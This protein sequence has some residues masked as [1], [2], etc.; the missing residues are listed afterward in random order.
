[1]TTVTGRRGYFALSVV[2]SRAGLSDGTEENFS[3][4]YG[5][6]WCLAWRVHGREGVVLKARQGPSKDEKIPAHL[7]SHIS[8]RMTISGFLYHQFLDAVAGGAKQAACQAAR[9]PREQVH[10]EPRRRL[11][12][13]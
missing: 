1:M 3:A 13:V 6:V 10:K 5:Q 4:T 2:Q 8:S 9:G 12:I 11:V 7:T